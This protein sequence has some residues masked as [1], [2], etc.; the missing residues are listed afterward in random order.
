MYAHLTVRTGRHAV[1]ALHG[2]L[3]LATPGSE[4]LA[5]LPALGSAASGL[6]ALDL[7]G[8]SFLD[9]S[10]LRALLALQQWIHREGGHLCLAATSPAVALV[11]DLLAEYLTSCE[12]CK[13]C[14]DDH[15]LTE[16]IEH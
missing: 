1:L 5:Q 14:L 16:I 8:V 9:C 11:F 13:P 10:G 12:L 6:V 2:E 7:S 15:D 3:D 4:L